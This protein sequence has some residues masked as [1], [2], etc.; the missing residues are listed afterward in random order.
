[1]NRYAVD[2]D[3]RRERASATVGPVGPVGAQPARKR[4]EAAIDLR[5]KSPAVPA[6]VLR[7]QQVWFARAV[8]T[9]EEGPA[10]LPDRDGLN[11]I[12]AI[13]DRLTDGPRL[14]ARERF[15]IYRRGY[16]ARLLECLVDDYPVL[17]HA[18]GEAA[19]E[20][21][22][23]AYIA[24]FPS[25]GPSLNAFGRRMAQFCRSGA[26]APLD[27]PGARAFAA[28]LADLEWTIVEMIHAPGSEPL[29]VDG[30][31]EV[32]MDAWAGARLVANTA[33]RLLRFGHPVNAYFQAFRSGGSPTIPEPAPSATVVYRSGPSV[34]RMDLTV[35]MFDVLSSLRAGESLG[36]AL[37][38]AQA[39]LGDIDERE[40]AARV[41]AWFR[42]WVTSG[43]FA[44]V[45]L[46]EGT[47]PSAR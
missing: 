27:A 11:A 18:L 38:R 4:D 41:L 39:S 46:G 32:P 29:T 40:A 3:G 1:M 31:R 15:D 7:D 24:A 28:D 35:P 21:L 10:T 14:S 20:D 16:H 8:M 43:L 19:F 6:T 47:D 5:A 42:E 26:P 30:L 12:H 2:V 13:T 23:R 37:A 17:Q 36:A 44:R 34:W 45:E 25:E 9:P 22:C 33:S